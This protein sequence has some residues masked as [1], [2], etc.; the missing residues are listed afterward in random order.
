MKKHFLLYLL[1][2]F[3]LSN[4]III[5]GIVLNENNEPIKDVNIYSKNIGTVSDEEGY[6]KI[7]LP[8]ILCVKFP[9]DYLRAMVQILGL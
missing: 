8:I 6:F 9:I 1:T 5:E 2:S 7:L 4:Q 3:L